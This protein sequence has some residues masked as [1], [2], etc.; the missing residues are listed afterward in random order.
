MYAFASPFRQR[1][2]AARRRAIAAIA[3]LGATLIAVLAGPAVASAAVGSLNV[4]VDAGGRV[5]GTGIDCPGDCTDS[6][7]WPDDQPAPRKVLT[8]TPQP[9]FRVE[10]TGCLV[11]AGRPNQ[12]TATFDELGAEVTVRFID[13]EPP[14]L[15][16]I[17]PTPEEG[18]FFG[19]YS[20]LPDFRV[21]PNDNGAV[22]RVE[23]R[24]VG[25][26]FATAVAAPWHSGLRAFG[27][28]ADGPQVF[29]ATAF[30]AAGNATSIERTINYDATKPVAQ[31]AGDPRRLTNA[32]SSTIEWSASDPNGP[33]ITATSCGLLRRPAVQYKPITCGWSVFTPHAEEGT[34]SLELRATDRVGN[35][36]IEYVEI[37][38]DRTAPVAP[39]ISAGMPEGG[40]SGSRDSRVRLTHP[41]MSDPVTWKCWS[42]DRVI[43]CPGGVADWTEPEGTTAVRF[44]ATVTDR[45]GN[46]GPALVRNW[47][48]DEMPPAVTFTEGPAE[49]AV[50]PAGDVTIAWSVPD[51]YNARSRCDWHDEDTTP[52]AQN[53]VT[54]RVVPGEYRLR[55]MVAD[56]RFLE[57]VLY[58]SFTVI[59]APDPGPG[60]GPGGDPGP[61]PGGDPG[62]GGGS[63]S[64]PGPG[65]GGSGGTPPGDPGLP[66]VLPVPG[67]LPPVPG[68]P[69][70]GSGSS[71]KRCV[72]LKVKRR[73]T[74]KAARRQLTRAGCRVKVKRVR[75]T[76]VKR[77]RV[78]GLS[79]KVGAKRPHRASVTIRVSRGPSR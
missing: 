40:V 24:D 42:N 44:R 5:T 12:C 23:F 62:P 29:R 13:I 27:T 48:I 32:A 73:A 47:T 4:T 70:S 19:P 55:V 54:R 9:G 76:S 7:A 2:R 51:R 78:V 14:T 30:D 71:A 20:T 56:D 18:K 22:A 1:A 8:A 43:P 38:V 41:E 68:G 53:R 26:L 57:T 25:T 52:C 16:F 66:P 63:G 65:S 37:T 59:A 75:S 17:D 50:I 36:A 15:S 6:E 10:W 67:G 28:R 21:A 31:V 3:L 60:P 69:P 74:L 39:Q 33:P 11:A 79:V 34:W 77:G 35:S 45:A 72:V 61:G 58:R 49:G 46:E 64:G